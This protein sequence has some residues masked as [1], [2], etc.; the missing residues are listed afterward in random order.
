MSS[1]SLQQVPV[2]EISSD[3]RLQLRAVESKE[4]IE[5]LL[6]QLEQGSGEAKRWP[7]PPL[8]LYRVP[9]EAKLIVV[10]GEHRRKAAC[11]AG[12][13]TVDAVV[14]DG[15]LHEA[16]LDAI[17]AN[18]THGLP[19]T[20]ED[21][22]R[23]IIAAL[24]HPEL[25]GK[26]NR[27]LASIAGV[28]HPTIDTVRKEL[29]DLQ[30]VVNLP[31]DD[32]ITAEWLK[33]PADQLNAVVRDH[34]EFRHLAVWSLAAYGAADSAISIRLGLSAA[35]V[36]RIISPLSHTVE[37][38]EC[39]PA[40]HRRLWVQLFKQELAEV[41]RATCETLLRYQGMP[42]TRLT[43]VLAIAQHHLDERATIDPQD[44]AAMAL[45]Q[46]A[47]SAAM[48]WLNSG[49][50]DSRAVSDELEESQ[51]IFQSDEHQK[52]CRLLDAELSLRKELCS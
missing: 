7:F 12:W 21:K 43:K 27:E 10:D 50:I 25:A 31:V 38:P 23:A 45:G 18:Q 19:R 42:G 32:A 15:T 44:N 13:S 48:K 37:A 34:A 26:S 22:R 6:E 9:G 49:L 17:K 29:A 33:L 52:W 35:H 3:R 40:E 5:Q 46:T 2:S 14:I 41:T 8:R 4:H 1:N 30:A 11:E 47:F 39:I 36:Q 51:A 16:A 28:S 24:K 20:R